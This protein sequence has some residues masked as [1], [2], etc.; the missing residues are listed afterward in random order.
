MSG[1]RADFD[2]GGRR[3]LHIVG[4]G[5]SGMSAVA[6]VLAEMGHRVSG[7]DGAASSVIDDLRSLGIDAV[8][9]HDAANVTAGIDALAVS[10]AIAPDNVEVRAAEGLGIPVLTR[11]ELLAA[12][13]ALRETVAVSGTHGKTTTSSLLAEVLNG[14]G[15]D[16]GF[17]VGA[18][19][20]SFGLAARWGSD[21]LFVVEADESD[22]SAFTLP[23]RAAVVTNVEPDHL[24]HHG[25]F[26]ALRRAFGRFIEQTPGPVAVCLDD[27]VAASLARADSWTYGVSRQARVRIEDPQ[28]DPLGVSWTLRIDGVEVG[29]ARLGRPGLH[30]A[31]NATAAVAIA[32]ALGVEPATA[33][34]ALDAHRGVARRFEPRGAAR[35]VT[36]IDDYAH[37]PTEVAAAL[38]AAAGGEWGRVV[39]V[40]QPHRYSR[41]EA[42]GATFADSFAAADVLIITDVYAAGE[43]PRPGVD[44]H[45]VFDP[46]VAASPSKEA[47]LAGTLEDVE[48]LLDRI[49]R[50]GD[51]CLTLGAGD[52]TTMPTRLLRRWGEL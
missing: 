51:L 32:A 24:E 8:V 41:T 48:D 39:A 31:R 15:R 26:D 3:R 36:F 21:E 4:I 34:A 10:S 38:A 2:L 45:S 19:I 5:G 49:L 40:F 52:L 7:S 1:A 13:C 17:L 6:T 43:P 20:S 16:A 30:N 44:G 42:L 27:P 46:V 12:I 11:A 22:G 14:A 29:R 33:L 50:P 18:R 35:G 37:L 9:G 25:D 23:R 28:Q 47:Y